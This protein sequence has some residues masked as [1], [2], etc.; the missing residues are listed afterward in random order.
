MV[1]RA[2]IFA[3]STLAC[4]ATAR[5]ARLCCYDLACGPIPGPAYQR[6]AANYLS[7]VVCPQPPPTVTQVCF[8]VDSATSCPPCLSS[9][10][11]SLTG[12]RPAALEQITTRTFASCQ[13]YAQVATCNP[14]FHW[15]ARKAGESLRGPSEHPATRLIAR[16]LLSV[17]ERHHG[18][19]PSVETRRASDAPLSRR[20]RRRGAGA[21]PKPQPAGVDPRAERARARPVVRALAGR[22]G[23]H[24]RRSRGSGRPRRPARAVRVCAAQLVLD[25]RHGSTLLQLPH[26]ARG[27]VHACEPHMV[28]LRRLL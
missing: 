19:A 12:Q 26:G 27:V 22:A 15:A 23:H 7:M 13:D 28:E 10:G 18:S 16:R 24:G 5:G 21:V 4:A 17:D 3:A 11:A 2:A 14:E 20:R 9:M 1:F 6:I 25:E 8:C